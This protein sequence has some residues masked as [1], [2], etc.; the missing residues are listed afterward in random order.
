MN[1]R[2][3]SDLSSFKNDLLTH[4]VT[5]KQVIIVMPID[6]I[7]Q[8]ERNI[9][10]YSIDIII[11]GHPLEKAGIKKEA[12]PVTSVYV[13]HESPEWYAPLDAALEGFGV[14]H[15]QIFLDRDT[16][17][18]SE[19]P[20]LGVYF[21]RLSGTAHT[22]GHPLAVEHC[23]VLLRRLEAHAR[24]IV[25]GREALE[26][27]MSKTALLIALEAAG[28]RIPA[29][30]TAISPDRVI[31]AARRFRRPFL[32]KPNRGGK[33]LGIIRCEDADQLAQRIRNGDLDH[34]AD[35]LYVIQEFVES[36]DP[37]IT[38]A[39]FV[40]G[41]F[42]YALLSETGG[43]FN[44]CPADAGCAVS[45]RPRFHI[46]TN[47]HHPILDEYRRFLR[48]YHVEIAAVEF[49]V[50][51]AGTAYTYDLNINTNYNAEAEAAAKRSG[52]NAIAAFLGRELEHL[53]ETQ[54]TRTATG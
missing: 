38:R 2:V 49:I 30:V 54:L 9:L 46:R 17:D 33:G 50:D 44:L 13:L 15:D 52:M 34:S 25:N 4:S 26:L 7:L 1:T 35:G 41:E 40:G 12:A 43:G 36:P 11:F 3:P 28:I 51:H 37:F 45:T 29:T 48:R 27:A 24:R 10:T 47:F 23:R 31:D 6:I 32:V 14:P 21:N 19:T 22:R 39:E 53:L 8:S 42:V 18:L 20:P 5:P 16:I